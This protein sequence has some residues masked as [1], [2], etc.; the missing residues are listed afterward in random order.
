MLIK[1]ADDMK[2]QSVHDTRNR[3]KSRRTGIM[4]ENNKVI[5]DEHIFLELVSKHQ[6]Y[7]CTR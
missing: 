5:I 3:S 4:V 7:I 1:A 2:L 6:L